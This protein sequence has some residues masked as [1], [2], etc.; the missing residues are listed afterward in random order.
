MRENDFLFRGEI[1]ELDPDVAELIR[2]E[3]A[4]Q[5]QHLILIPSESTVPHAV[6]GALS[7]AFHN[8]YAEGYPLE[9]T[10]K[11][12]Q[13]EL[14]D[15]DARLPEFR[16]NAD[17]RYYKGHGIRQHHRVIGAAAGG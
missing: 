14:L 4:R 12:S 11:L 5:Q 1:D 15:Y 3:T 8:I 7:S 10:R 9:S 6:R 17:L 2:H 13:A 16:R